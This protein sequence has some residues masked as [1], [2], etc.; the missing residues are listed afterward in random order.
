MLSLVRA[1]SGGCWHGTDSLGGISIVLNKMGV[2][3]LNRCRWSKGD[4]HGH[5]GVHFG[6]TGGVSNLP[7]EWS[8][9]L[10]E[11]LSP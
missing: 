10:E 1:Q 8:D 2:R 7:M 4:V 9:C 6:I 11:V 3:G 5:G